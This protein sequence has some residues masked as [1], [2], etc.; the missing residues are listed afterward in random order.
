APTGDSVQQPLRAGCGSPQGRRKTSPQ[1]CHWQHGMEPCVH[2]RVPAHTH[3]NVHCTHRTQS[4]HHG[5]RKLVL[6]KGSEMASLPITS[7]RTNLWAGRKLRQ[8]GSLS[9]RRSGASTR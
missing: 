7:G 3:R 6:Q 5:A 2:T 4:T 1:S 8:R 9:W